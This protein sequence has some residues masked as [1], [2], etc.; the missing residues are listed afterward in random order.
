MSKSERRI[1]FEERRQIKREERARLPH[2]QPRAVW[3]ALNRDREMHSFFNDDF[4]VCH[5]RP[6]A[7]Y[8][9][10]TGRRGPNLDAHWFNPLRWLAAA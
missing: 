4:P 1:A 10:K 7:G 8:I 2:C 9:T 5:T 3:R 6:A